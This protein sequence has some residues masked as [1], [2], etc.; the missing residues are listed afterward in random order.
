M[1]KVN[2]LLAAVVA[3]SMTMPAQ[4][5]DVF[6]NGYLRS[7]VS[8]KNITTDD[9]QVAKLGRAGYENNTYILTQVSSTSP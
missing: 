9:P 8:A 4:A 2:L 6:F 3:A 1:K 7:G 5:G